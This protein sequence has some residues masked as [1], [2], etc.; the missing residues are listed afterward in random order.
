M[1][2]VMKVGRKMSKRRWMWVVKTKLFLFTVQMRRVKVN[3]WASASDYE[4]DEEP[5]FDISK[6]EEAVAAH[7]GWLQHVECVIAG[8]RMLLKSSSSLNCGCLRRRRRLLRIRT[9]VFRRSLFF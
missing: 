5:L 4:E 1:K 6:S 2:R 7:K 8:F 3:A 9:L